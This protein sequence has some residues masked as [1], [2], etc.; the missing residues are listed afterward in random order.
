MKPRESPDT[1]I[2][3]QYPEVFKRFP[4]VLIRKCEVATALDFFSKLTQVLQL[5]PNPSAF[6]VALPFE[7]HI[8]RHHGHSRSIM[9]ESI[10]MLMCC[11]NISISNIPSITL[12]S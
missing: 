5:G 11:L 12:S 4:D 8:S 10:F 7:G 6:E 2:N 9:S 3:S 1:E